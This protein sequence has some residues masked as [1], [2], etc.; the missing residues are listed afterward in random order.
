MKTQTAII[1]AAI[2][3]G[4]VV[5]ASKM[6]PRYEV[7]DGCTIPIRLDRWSGECTYALPSSTNAAINSG[8][9]SAEDPFGIPDLPGGAGEG[10]REG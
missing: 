1:L 8:G 7:Y 2:I 3:L 6:L 4:G 10:R 9:M 5:L